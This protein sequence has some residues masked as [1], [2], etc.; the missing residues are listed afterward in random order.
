MF[1]IKKFKPDKEGDVMTYAGISQSAAREIMV[2]LNVWVV[3]QVVKVQCSSGGSGRWCVAYVSCAGCKSWRWCLCFV[4][5]GR[6]PEG[7]QTWRLGSMGGTA[8]PED[9]RRDQ[10]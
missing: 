10:R 9:R 1:A 3:G 7:S 6:Q 4:W 5:G 8:A 2:S